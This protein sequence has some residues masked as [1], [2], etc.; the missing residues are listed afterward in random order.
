MQALRELERIRTSYGPGAGAEKAARI[1]IL[2]TS[3]FERAPE[4]LR[5]HEILCFL[6]AYP[7]DEAVLAAA[8]H[9][10]AGFP[11]RRDLARHRE[12]LA[13]TGVA[14]TP[15]HYRFFW[16]T[17]RWLAGRWPDRLTLDG[18]L[19]RARLGKLLPQG[20][21]SAVELVTAIDRLDA[22]DPIREHL[23][24]DLDPAYR[25]DAGP[26]TPSRTAAYHPLG[27]P[28]FREAP[29][30][31]ARPNLAAE[32]RRPPRSIRDAPIAE[33]RALVDLA[34]S[35]MVTRSRDLDAFSYG[36]PR[37]V[38]IADDGGGLAFAFIGFVP[39]RRL[40]VRTGYGALFL[41]NGVPIGYGQSDAFLG[42]AEIS[43]NVFETFRGVEAARVFARYL[44]AV[45]AFLGATRF[46]I[47]PYQLGL[48]NE[49]GVASGAFWFYQK[50]GFEP[51]DP[52]A[53]RIVRAELARMRAR[54]G[55]RSS[56]R[57]L[58][59]LA[60]HHVYFSIDRL[61]PSDPTIL[62]RRAA[63][64]RTA[65]DVVTMRRLFGSRAPGSRGE[66]LWID[67]W[68]P[69]LASLDGFDRLSR[70][71]RRR[72]LDVARAKGGRR[73][74]DALRSLAD[75]PKLAKMLWALT[76]ARW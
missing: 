41:Q 68:A 69:L 35:A 13:D 42:T 63:E 18:P 36:D 48:G 66:R 38:S 25:L 34:R 53:K 3:R 37:D 54:P 16:P 10:L 24:D 65:L 39:E 5:F 74:R 4:L 21:L 73:E 71:E 2:A 75:H 51:A 61:R 28:V 55:H 49:E 60:E 31:R 46:G 45:R 52:G 17:A 11:R 30:E 62:D 20:D 1:A 26:D 23:H 15:I 7:D 50:L 44:A 59:R 32:A 72:A 33:G 76:R 47:E 22:S 27:A 56:R 29:F 58:E 6:R 57:T 40:P 70:V 9:A 14:G 43:F 67:R 8:A 19:D 64:R 12:A